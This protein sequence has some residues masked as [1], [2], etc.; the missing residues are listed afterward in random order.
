[1]SMTVPTLSD[2]LGNGTPKAS[3]VTPNVT[4]KIK[5]MKRDSF[6]HIIILLQEELK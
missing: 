1:M 4:S 2:S 3:F 5:E 6:L